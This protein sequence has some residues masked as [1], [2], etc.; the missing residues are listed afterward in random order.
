MPTVTGSS[1]GSAVPVTVGRVEPRRA[2]QLLDDAVRQAASRPRRRPHAAPRRAVDAR[3]GEEAFDQRGLAHPGRAL[4]QHDPRAAGGGVGERPTQ[5]CQLGRAT[6]EGRHGATLPTSPPA[7]DGPP[8]PT[9]SE[10]SPPGGSGAAIRVRCSS[11]PAPPVVSASYQYAATSR[12]SVVSSTSSTD[13]PGQVERAERDRVDD[14]DADAG[15]HQ[16]EQGL[17]RV[18]GRAGLHRAAAGDELGEHLRGVVGRACLGLR[19]ADDHR[20]ATSASSV[21]GLPARSSSWP[22]GTT[23]CSGSRHSTRSRRPG[24]SGARHPWQHGDRGSVAQQPPFDV[25]AR[26][27]DEGHPHAGVG[28]H[29][30]GQHRGEERGADARGG[31]HGDRLGVHPAQRADRGARGTDVRR[32][33]PGRAGRRP[34]PPRSAGQAGGCGRPGERPGHAPGRRCAR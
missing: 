25:E 1:S 26:P 10:G 34:R 8:D 27:L 19:P 29:Q 20:S 5:E 21:T 9:P 14:A 28:R 33:P 4:D 15:P 13:K 18:D 16:R 22:T 11:I 12:R 6:D 3:L 7:R 32:R 31:E 24:G 17:R 23:T 2:H 30:L